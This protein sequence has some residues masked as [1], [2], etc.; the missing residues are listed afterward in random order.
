MQSDA[1]KPSRK[2]RNRRLGHSDST[3]RENPFAGL[4]RIDAYNLLDEDALVRIEARADWLLKEIGIEF[5]DDE[6]ACALFRAAGADV[7]G[8]RVRFESGM[9]R[10]LCATAPNQFTLHARDPRYTVHI[11]GDHLVLMPGYGSPFVTDLDRGR[12]YSTLEDF[13]NFVK[14]TYMTPWLHHSG[15]T[16]C[17]PVDIPV[18]KRHLDMVYAHLRLS[19]KPFMGSVTSPARAADSITMAQLVFGQHFMNQNCVMQG[20]INVNSPFIYD[21]AM[22]G[23]LRVYA[24]ANQCVAISPA[25]FGGAMGPVSPAAIAAQ[26]LA[27]AMAG[28]ALSQLVRP[29]CP[30]VFGSFH[31]TMNL[32]S[33]S[34]TFGTPEANLVTMVLS[35]LGSRL[36]V[37]VRSGGGQIT[38][39]N[40]ADG[41]A[42]QDSSDAMWATLISGANQVWHAAGWLEGGLTMSYE[43]FVMD[44]DHCGMMLRLLGGVAVNDEALP[45]TPYHEVDVGENFLATTHT[46]RHFATCNFQP[47]I[48]DAGAYEIWMENGAPTAEQRANQRWKEMLEAYIPPPI[49]PATKEA[50]EAFVAKHKG[51]LP[52]AWY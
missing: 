27:E 20:N 3:P 39:T 50:L 31:S 8:S 32:K 21:A 38:A 13:H 28:I 44:A 29:G 42:M 46:I 51:E 7:Q 49:D 2:G 16:V 47:D 25:I 41:Q 48:A 18:N 14:L 22:S 15:G 43:K 23:A 26:T 30:V 52:D 45:Q 5:R 10:Q 33:G 9:A 12:R 37:P 17:E 40:S 4:K 19:A 35:Q 11:G 34:L 24:E 36:G 1:H 6:V